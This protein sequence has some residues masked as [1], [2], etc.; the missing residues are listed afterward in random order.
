MAVYT[1]QAIA[2]VAVAAGGRNMFAEIVVTSWKKGNTAGLLSKVS[3][4]FHAG[5]LLSW[6]VTSLS[7]SQ[8][9]DGVLSHNSSVAAC[10]QGQAGDA[11]LSQSS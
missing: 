3:A 1:A 11:V 8:T 2:A 9:S 7:Y 10:M 6:H 4:T 5:T